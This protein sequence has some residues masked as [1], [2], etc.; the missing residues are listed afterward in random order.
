MLPH[1]GSGHG[2]LPSMVVPGSACGFV[3]VG[4]RS[5]RMGRDK[6]RL[7]YRSRPLAHYQAE[8]LASVT[9]RALLVGKD[10]QPFSDWP[11][12]F[13]QDRVEEPA[14]IHG[15][16]AALEAAEAEWNLIL[17]ADLPR[18]PA[19]FL[20][21]L[22]LLAR[23]SGA[24]AVLPTAGGFLQ[25]LCGVWHVSAGPLL[26][27]R[28]ASGERSLARATAGLGAS[29]LSEKETASMPG[30]AAASFLNVNTP[31][32]YRRLEAEGAAETS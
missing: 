20:A 10:P 19:D 15:V 32:E 21:A 16:V 3:L 4:G 29:V 13:L 17:A 31:D 11:F 5:S 12:S 8:K 27:S 9:G 23:P 24:I 22:L 26:A 18:V 2:I 25:T 14:A 30:G 7:A 1:G 6:T 28:V